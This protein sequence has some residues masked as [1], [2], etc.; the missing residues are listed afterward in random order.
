MSLRDYPEHLNE[1]Y[2]L[3]N[4]ITLLSIFGG[5]GSAR[6][7]SCSQKRC[8]EPQRRHRPSVPPLF[9]CFSK[10]VFA[11]N[12][13]FYLVDL[14]KEKCIYFSCIHASM[15]RKLF[16]NKLLLYQEYYFYNYS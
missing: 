14:Y 12:Q 3:D 16:Q 9:Q 13:K 11:Y 4:Y 6:K 2:T 8:H 1:D 15:P 5:N 10:K 7:Y